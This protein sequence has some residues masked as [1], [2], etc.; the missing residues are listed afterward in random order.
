[1]CLTDT[2]FS[3]WSCS[4]SDGSATGLVR[5]WSASAAES[6]IAAPKAS[7]KQ[8]GAGAPGATPTAFVTEVPPASPTPQAASVAAPATSSA[9]TPTAAARASLA[10]TSAEHV[11]GLPA[12]T[13]LAQVATTQDAA[14]AAALLELMNGARLQQ[15]LPALERDSELEAVALARA[16]NLIA[17]GY[18]DHYSASGESA[19]SELA[20]RGIRYRLAGEN[21][22][23]N[24]YIESETMQAAF[25]A[26]MASD[27][28]RANIMEPRYSSAGVA[29]VLSGHVWIYVTMLRTDGPRYGVATNQTLPIPCPFVSPGALS[30]AKR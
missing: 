24:N 8:A 7:A 21:L 5:A 20:A 25:D 30:G 13:A 16:D 28:H 14:K 27:G 6:A 23:R 4:A 17:N 12:A 26:L 18:F 2:R 11:A 9:A 1:V 19:S 15:G 3:G 29:A 22:A 10:S